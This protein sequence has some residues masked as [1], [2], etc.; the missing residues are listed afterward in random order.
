MAVTDEADSQGPGGQ[1]SRPPARLPRALLKRRLYRLRL[2]AGK[3]LREAANRLKVG[4]LTIR[5]YE[6]GETMPDATKLEALCAFYGA[7]AE[8]AAEL[9]HLRSSAGKREWWKRYGGR[10]DSMATLLELE[11]EADRIRQYDQHAIPGPLQTPAYARAIMEA[12]ELGISRMDL[13]TG[14][15]LRLERQARIFDGNRDK[16]ITFIVDQTALERMPGG[17]VTRR[18]QL[19]RLRRPPEGATVLVLPFSAGPHP[20][21]TGFSIFE[22]DIE[23]IP[24]AVYTEWSAS[25]NAAVIEDE[26]DAKL[27]EELWRRILPLT[28]DRKRSSEFIKDMM[29]STSDA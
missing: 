23:E 18:A 15:E 24:K 22:F 16:D 21:L 5:R 13:S 2:D 28:L 4:D 10:P 20:A 11:P 19:A 9:E 12:L 14:V 27:Y 7:S 6:N 3:S 17:G 1:S 26:E 29:E 8:T 25:T